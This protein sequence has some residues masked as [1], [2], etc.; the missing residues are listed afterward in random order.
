MVSQ[1]EKGMCLRVVGFR[2]KEDA[3][4]AIKELY[5]MEFKG[6]RLY[7]QE[8][9]KAFNPHFYGGKSML[10]SNSFG[11]GLGSGNPGQ[12][13]PPDKLGDL[14]GLAGVSY[15]TDPLSCTV[16]VG[17]LDKVVNWQK[18]KRT[19]TTIG[20]VIRADIE[21]DSD[22]ISKGCGTVVFEKATEALNAVSVLHGRSL[23]NKYKPMTVRMDP[24][25]PV[26]Q[27]LW[28]VEKLRNSLVPVGGGGCI[29]GLDGFGSSHDNN[30]STSDGQVVR[31]PQYTTAG[32]TPV[33]SPIFQLPL[34]AFQPCAMSQSHVPS[35][36]SQPCAMSQSHVPSQPSQP[37]AMIQS[38]VPSQPSQPCAM[39]QSHVPSQPSQPCA[40]SQSHVPSQPSQPCAM[41]QSDVPSQPSQ[42]CAMS[43]SHV[44]SQPSQPC[45]M[46]QS[47]VPSQPS[48]VSMAMPQI[49]SW[50]HL[51]QQPQYEAAAIILQQQQQQQ[52]LHQQQQQLLYQQQQQWQLQQMYPTAGMNMTVESH[53]E[54]KNPSTAVEKE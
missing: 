7:V 33:Q 1:R 2:R 32:Q 20:N 35:Q 15:R 27:Q 49:A 50:Y 18:L 45:A 54:C 42:P 36:P 12:E 19:F 52:Q 47:H 29:S 25:A 3:E 28:N 23:V 16:F 13:G 37:W 26:L 44:P 40:I 17:N 30:S 34:G 8:D 38:D 22:L 43:Q 21:L 11:S 48:P 41:I 53:V 46:I 9:K 14:L 10:L 6:R 31:K 24:T 5:G 4:R 51:Y 39:S